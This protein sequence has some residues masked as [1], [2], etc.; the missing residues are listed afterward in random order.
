MSCQPYYVS[1]I[2]LI[3]SASS[4]SNSLVVTDVTETIQPAPSESG[5]EFA[6]NP[7]VQV[8]HKRPREAVDDIDN[9]KSNAKK[10]KVDQHSNLEP[11]PIPL[12]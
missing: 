11:I 5:S 6:E 1:Y 12:N 9:E 10:R 4:R 8:G 7:S 3:F 2:N